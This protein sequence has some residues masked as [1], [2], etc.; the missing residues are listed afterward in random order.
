MSA[1]SYSDVLWWIGCVGWAAIECQGEC[2]S[3]HCVVIVYNVKSRK[4]VDD[5]WR[6]KDHWWFALNLRLPVIERKSFDNFTAPER[7]SRVAKHLS[8]ACKLEPVI[9]LSPQT[10]QK[11]ISYPDQ[12]DIT[13]VQGHHV[14][15]RNVH[16]KRYFRKSRRSKV[17]LSRL[18][19]SIFVLSAPSPTFS[20]G[21]AST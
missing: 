14:K 1:F 6:H 17:L 19:F 2:Q 12:I 8:Y 20:D 15:K 9:L 10:H 4:F 11:T 7:S 16:H 21:T 3:W 13:T 5:E 18:S